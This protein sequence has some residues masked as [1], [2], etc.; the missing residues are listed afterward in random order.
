MDVGNREADFRQ[1]NLL[2]WQKILNS[3]KIGAD[4]EESFANQ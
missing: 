3:K 4:I 2:S 1:K